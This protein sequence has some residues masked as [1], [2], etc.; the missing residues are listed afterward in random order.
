M[1][2]RAIRYIN[3]NAF[4]KTRFRKPEKNMF[5]LKT[6]PSLSLITAGSLDWFTTVIGIAFFGAV[7]GNPLMAQLTSNSLLLY[8]IIKLLTTIM[9]GLIFYKTEK[10]LSNVEDKNSKAF[11]LTRTGVRMIYVIATIALVIAVLNNIFVVTQ[12]I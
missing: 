1:S 3:K 6:I 7:E 8:S 11:R 4:I 5:H 2:I 10:I 9:V 12:A